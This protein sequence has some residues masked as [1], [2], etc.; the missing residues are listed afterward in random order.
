MPMKI[1]PN[2]SRPPRG[3]SSDHTKANTPPHARAQTRTQCNGVFQDFDLNFV[4]CHLAQIVA[5]SSLVDELCV[6]SERDSSGFG[7]KETN[8]RERER[9]R[10][11]AEEDSASNERA[12]SPQVLS[13]S[14]VYNL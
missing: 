7:R 1:I 3:S 10:E 5:G 14:V 9:E 2:F 8:W 6:A 13:L 11:E 4:V 12:F